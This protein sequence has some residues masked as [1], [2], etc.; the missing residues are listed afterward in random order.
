MAEDFTIHGD[1]IL[2]VLATFL[3]YQFSFEKPLHDPQV[4][5]AKGDLLLGSIF[6]NKGTEIR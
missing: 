5:R 6:K 4:L 3:L 2:G 1:F